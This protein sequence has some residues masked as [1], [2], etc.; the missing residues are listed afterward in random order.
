VRYAGAGQIGAL[1]LG[2]K[3][4][5]RLTLEHGQRRI[6]PSAKQKG[7]PEKP[8]F[9]V[10]DPS[11]LLEGAYPKPVLVRLA[12]RTALPLPQ[13]VGAFAEALMLRLMPE[14]VG[15]VIRTTRLLPKQISALSNGLV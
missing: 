6:V 13:R 12:L 4:K 10:L 7:R 1:R 5:A 9:R 8:P 15:A 14:V 11:V 2:G 3:V